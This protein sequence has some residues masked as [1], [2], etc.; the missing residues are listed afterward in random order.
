MVIW[1]VLPYALHFIKYVT[2]LIISQYVMRY[3]K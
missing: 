2:I 3:S 1:L